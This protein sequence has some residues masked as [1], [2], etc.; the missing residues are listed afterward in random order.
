VLAIFLNLI[1]KETY[2]QTGA[3]L[4]KILRQILDNPKIPQL[5]P[6]KAT[7]HGINQRYPKRFKERPPSRTITPA[8]EPAVLERI[9]FILL[10]HHQWEYPC[11]C[12]VVTHGVAIKEGA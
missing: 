10:A 4:S 3:H 6:I 11:G 2:H 7:L 12:G 5:I 1:I 9:P 8:T